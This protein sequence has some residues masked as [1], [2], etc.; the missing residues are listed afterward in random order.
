LECRKFFSPQKPAIDPMLL[1]PVDSLDQHLAHVEL[2][3]AYQLSVLYWVD[4]KNPKKWKTNLGYKLK[5]YALWVKRF[6]RDP[7]GL[8]ELTSI[9]TGRRSQ[10]KRLS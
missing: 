8:R 2:E 9:L 6:G 7:W 3:V 10:R 1:D 4:F 5:F